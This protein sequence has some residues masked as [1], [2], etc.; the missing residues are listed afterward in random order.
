MKRGTGSIKRASAGRCIFAEVT[1]E[2]EPHERSTFLVDLEE[3]TE[4]WDKTYLSTI[5]AAVTF[6]KEKTLR[7][8]GREDL[9]NV[10]VTLRRLVVTHADTTSTAVFYATLLAIQDALDIEIPDVE[11]DWRNRELRIKF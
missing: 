6:A 8:L 10:S 2:V 11:A 9:F 1:L 5:Q 7:I 4:G 3:N